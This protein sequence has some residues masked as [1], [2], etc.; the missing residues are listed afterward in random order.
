MLPHY[1]IQHCKILATQGEVLEACRQLVRYG[2]P[3]ESQNFQLYKV[4]ANELLSSDES[5]APKMLREML[6]RLLAPGP[7]STPV[8]PKKLMEDRSPPSTEFHRAALVAHYQS[9]RNMLKERQGG[10]DLCWKISCAL[11]RYCTEFPVDRAFYQAGMDCKDS[12]N[13][14][15]AFFFLNRYLD[16]ADAIDDPENAQIDG[17]DFIDTDIPSPY[18]LDLPESHYSTE[19]QVEDIRDWVLGWS[20][21]ANVQQKMDSRP[22]DSCKAD[23]YAG[24]LTCPKC[25][26]KHEPCAV[27]GYPV[28]KRN[29]VECSNCG[30]SANRDEWNAFLRFFKTCP[31]CSVPQNP[32]Y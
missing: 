23:I 22:C 3:K 32:Q 18:D 27:S 16:I 4:L 12:G 5:E 29:R 8:P 11:C 24:T 15:M 7:A 28:L 21:D 14:N 19:S 31:W 1:L 2:P 13:I 9:L 25:N 26:Y 6:L 20:M 10:M 30:C 17:S